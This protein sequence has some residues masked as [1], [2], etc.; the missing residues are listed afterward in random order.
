MGQFEWARVPFGLKNAGTHFCKMIGQVFG[1]YLRARGLIAFVDDLAGSGPTFGEALVLLDD[2]LTVAVCAGIRFNPK[3]CQFFKQ[4]MIFLGHE[5]SATGVKPDPAKVKSVLE[6]PPPGDATGVR[7]FLGMMNFY[8]RFVTAFAEIARPLFCLTSGDKRRKI[9]WNQQHQ[10]SFDALK[11]ALVSAPCLAYPDFNLD[12]H[13]VVYGDKN[14]IGATL[15]QQ[16]DGSTE[17]HPL[18]RSSTLSSLES[19]EM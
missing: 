2:T 12:F 13:L 18:S 16:P 3:K 6:L 15:Q 1:G 7:S 5:I 10:A 8:K 17:R 11:G 14:G 9:E 4:A 19:R